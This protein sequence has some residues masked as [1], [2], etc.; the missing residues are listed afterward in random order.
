MTKRGFNYMDNQLV[1][2]IAFLL[3][4]TICACENKTGHLIH[5]DEVTPWCIIDFDSLNRSP[6]QRIAMLK[7]MGFKKYGFNRGKGQLGEMK[8]EFNLA[9][10]NDIEITSIFLWLNAKR[11]SLGKL[12]PSNQE[13]LSNLKE[14]EQKPTI[15]VSFSNNFF[16]K[17]NDQESI[18]FSVEM[19]KYIKLK[20]DEVGCQLALYNHHGWF[21]NPYNQIEIL[22]VLNQNTITMVYNFHH[23]HSLCT[24]I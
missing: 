18:D 7:D 20:A 10:K 23:A 5:V 9:G 2:S 22:K 13:L 12:G 11:D 1:L 15:W 4:I 8:K 3:S 24:S 17:R 16:E 6:E 14:V 19:I 21:G